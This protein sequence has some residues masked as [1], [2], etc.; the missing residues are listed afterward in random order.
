MSEFTPADAGLAFTADVPAA[1]RKAIATVTDNTAAED[2][3]RLVRRPSS[4]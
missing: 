4:T 1:I 2:S 3:G